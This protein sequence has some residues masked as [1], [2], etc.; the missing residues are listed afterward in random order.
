MTLNAPAS[1]T[2]PPRRQG[3]RGGNV[4][5]LDG[6]RGVAS[7]VVVAWH[8]AYTFLPRR[9][10][11]VPPFDPAAGLVGNPAFAL[12]NGPGAVMLFLVLSGYVLPLGYFQSGRSEVVLR[13][14]AKRWFR[15]AGL[16][17]LAAVGSYLLFR[18]GLYRY[19]QAAAFTGS[20]WLGSFG[21]GDVNGRLQPSLLS[22]VLEG[23]VFAFVGRSD[24]YD[25]VF[26]TMRGELFGSLM[27]FGLALMLHRCRVLTGAA[28]LVLAAAATQ[29]T[30]PRL[31]AFVA[32]L[33]LSWADARGVVSVPRW[34][35]PCCLVAGLLLFGYLEPR[36]AY[37]WLG[38]LHDGSEW[39]YDRIWLH[40]LGGVLLILGVPGCERASAVMASCGARLL[41]RLSFPVYLFHFPL[42]CSLTC[43]LF[44]AARPLLPHDAA[45]AV[46]AAGTLPALLAAGYAFARADELWV[47]QLNRVSRKA[48]A[49]PDGGQ[50][51]SNRTGI[52]HL[53]A[54]GEQP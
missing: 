25:P 28:L 32:G 54:D 30:D 20:D 42:L 31:A 33:A 44:L 37:A 51:G 5:E 36:G 52:V 34:M 22:A 27:V 46:A 9:I 40:T 24:A 4:A 43:R 19:R 16:T 17:L 7:L 48:I 10:G 47:A 29:C 39:R 8:F 49:V 41:G 50:A 12:L 23:A 35:A 11:I 38:F 45:V 15:L 1:A 14:V 26:W 18:F 2:D 3:G 6:L 13:A 21:G 53:H